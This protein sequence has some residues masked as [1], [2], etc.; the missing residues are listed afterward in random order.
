MKQMY[1]IEMRPDPVSLF[2]ML[3]EQG[4]YRYGLE[5][6]PGYAV[7]AWLRAAFGDIAPKPFRLYQRKGQAIRVLG[8]AGVDEATLSERLS[9]FAE[10][11]V[12]KVCP[13][14]LI[15]GRPM[16]DR[17]SEGRLL[18]FEVLC[19]PTVRRNNVEKD[20]FLA[21]ADREE[22]DAELDRASIYVEWLQKK[23][24]GAAK[25]LTAGLDGFRLCK[26]I[27]RAQAKAD[28]RKTKKVVF[29]QA[30]LTGSLE[31]IDKQ[32]FTSLLKQGI[33]RH[34]AFGYGMLL[35]RPVS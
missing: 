19:C 29:P 21:R 11:S 9:D 2:K 20:A 26:H 25:I 24:E 5:E 30:V 27:R 34:K 3:E 8:Y 17:F 32:A 35:L 1:M 7:H 18:G 23:M 31:V 13:P 15:A 10:P 6:D 28:A 4:V 16:P 33:G 12:F 22:K 14:D